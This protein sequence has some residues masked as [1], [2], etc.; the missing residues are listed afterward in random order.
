MKLKSRL[1]VFAVISLCMTA[2]VFADSGAEQTYQY[3][4]HSVSDCNNIANVMNIPYCQAAFLSAQAMEQNLASSLKNATLNPEQ[5]YFYFYQTQASA[6]SPDQT[7]VACMDL[8][9]GKPLC[10]LV[11]YSMAVGPI[12]P[13][14]Q[15]PTLRDFPSY[16]LFLNNPISAFTDFQASNPIALGLIKNLGQAGYTQFIQAYPDSNF[17]KPYDPPLI[18]GGGGGGWGAE[19]EAI[20]HNSNAIS[21]LFTFGGGG[22]G[23][24]TS[25]ATTLNLGSGGG[26]GAQFASNSAGNNGLGLGGGMGNTDTQPQLSYNSNPRKSSNTYNPIV[27]TDYQQGLN[28]LN[29]VLNAGI[30]SNDSILLVGGGGMGGGVE[31]LLETSVHALSTQGGFQFRYVFTA[32]SASTDEAILSLQTQTNTNSQVYSLIGPAYQTANTMAYNA[33]GQNYNN[34]SCICPKAHALVICLLAQKVG[35]SN[36]PSWLQQPHCGTDAANQ[37]YSAQALSQ[38]SPYQ[39]SLIDAANTSSLMA[40]QDTSSQA[41]QCPALLSSYFTTLNTTGAAYVPTA[42]NS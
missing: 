33:C 32:A 37:A 9:A 11:Q 20:A 26:G 34:F 19:I 15:S 30:Q 5:S 7:P 28:Q 17:T 40:T 16:F 4:I 41:M 8:G 1:K 35:A 36:V 29:T 22:G 21:T 18:S 39:Q 25:S 13:N 12:T 27:I 42:T 14:N 38:F 2:H 10:G 3:T 24:M 31:Y 6:T 23:G